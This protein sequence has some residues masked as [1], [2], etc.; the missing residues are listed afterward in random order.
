MRPRILKPTPIIYLAF[1]KNDLFIYFIVHNV[2]IFICYPLILYIRT[3]HKKKCPMQFSM[4]LSKSTL[5][6]D[7]AR[8]VYYVTDIHPMDRGTNEET[9]LLMEKLTD[10]YPSMRVR[11]LLNFN[12]CIIL[13]LDS[14]FILYSASKCSFNT[15]TDLYNVQ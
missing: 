15:P 6:S 5:F 13:D 8:Y 2:D 11:S 4:R 9:D 7:I 14:T 10:I 3:E 12:C 1:K